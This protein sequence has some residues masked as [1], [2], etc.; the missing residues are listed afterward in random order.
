[1]NK[2]ICTVCILF[3]C[4][5]NG[6]SQKK[7][8]NFSGFTEKAD[9]YLNAIHNV[10]EF[11]GTVL[12][13][14]KGQ[15]KFHKGYGFASK[16]FKIPNSPSTKFRVGSVTKSF[17]AISILQLVEQGKLKLKDP[18]SKYI[19]DYPFANQIK[20]ENLLSH[21]SGIKRDIKFPDRTK[22][23]TLKELITMSKVD[24]L[25]YEPGTKMS[26]SNCGYIL[27]HHILEKLTGEKYE[28]YVTKNVLHP[29]GL[30]NT[31]IEDPLSP[32]EGL[33]DGF[34]NGVNK[35]G[36][37][38]YSEVHMSSHGYSDAVGAMYSTT[39]DLLKFSRQ[40][41]KSNILKQETWELAL[42]PFV[43]DAAPGYRWGFGF[44]IIEGKTVKVINHN[45]RTTGFRGG[46]FQFIEDDLTIIILGNHMD[47][48]RG[49]ILMAFQGMLL[50]KK[51][52]QPQTRATIGT[53]DL[54]LKDYVGN[55]KTA[56]FPFKISEFKNQLYVESHGDVPSKLLP[57][58]QDSFFCKYFD[59][60]LKFKRENG[61]IIGCEWIY[62][63]KPE[64]AVK[65]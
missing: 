28:N 44:N 57:F 60:T 61:K 48:A 63:N 22:T 31:G 55:Y 2:T 53:D 47:A 27:L 59:L 36:Y 9:S 65:L 16:R 12:V 42:Q 14:H 30:F 46:Y 38:T 41:G 21:T 1:M 13:A 32:P 43:K 26:Y 25:L 18:L 45:G 3:I 35:E 33:A 19:P 24:S 4:I 20:I 56:G 5:S 10:G 29:L 62:K 40:I 58:K 17:T 52:Y 34:S 6:F 15:I 39:E 51:Y 23:Y 8:I 49:T 64:Q 50:D 7:E 54:I 37:F 11:S